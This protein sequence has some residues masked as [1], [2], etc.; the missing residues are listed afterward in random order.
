MPTLVHLTTP[1]VDEHDDAGEST[2]SVYLRYAHGSAGLRGETLGG[3]WQA[4]WNCGGL[5]CLPQG[6][7]SSEDA[8]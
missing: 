6:L 7:Q 5:G 8:F 2:S 3:F 1:V 4:S